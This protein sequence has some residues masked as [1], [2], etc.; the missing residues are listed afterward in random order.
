MAKLSNTYYSKAHPKILIHNRKR[1]AEQIISCFKNIAPQ[2]RLSSCMLLDVGS[3]NGAITYY[4]SKNVKMVIGVDTDKIAIEDGIKSF[5]KKNMKL[6][7]FDG[8]H[9][10]FPSSSFDLLVFRRTYGSVEDLEELIKELYRVLKPS[11][12]CYFEGHNRLFPFESDYKFPFL[13]LLSPKWAGKYVTLFGSKKF[14]IGKYKTFWG[15]KKMFSQ[16]EII[17]VTPLILKDPRKFSFLRLYRY[18]FITKLMPLSLLQ[19][20]EPFFP[21]FIWILK[22]TPSGTLDR[23]SY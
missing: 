16:F 22:K 14:Y 20:L 9:I 8:K 6:Q 10:P 23:L 15:L 18:L 13:P 17:P 11:G 7:L 2:L 1:V 19:L 12:L 21:D 3:S 5:V 4:L